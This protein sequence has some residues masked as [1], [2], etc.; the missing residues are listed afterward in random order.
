MHCAPAYLVTP[1]LVQ[2]LPTTR[3]ANPRV[4][5]GAV[6][7]CGIPAPHL[8][9]GV[10]HNN[11]AYRCRVYRVRQ[12]SPPDPRD[13]HGLVYIEVRY[14]D[15][16]GYPQRTRRASGN[17]L[18]LSPALVIHGAT[19]LLTWLILAALVTRPLL[20]APPPRAA[21]PAPAARP[22]LPARAASPRTQAQR[23]A[24]AHIAD[25]DAQVRARIRQRV[26]STVRPI[27]PLHPTAK[28][29]STR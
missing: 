26:A 18:F 6:L 27:L 25:L 8:R 28:L 17:P 9:L 5:L 21:L 1:D 2:E 20:P 16:D 19:V 22:L 15:P 24:E 3:Y 10:V 13:R 29:R 4:T 23:L 14:I 11:R 12:P 7:T